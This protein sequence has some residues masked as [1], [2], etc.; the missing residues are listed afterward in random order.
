MTSRRN[1]LLKKLVG[2]AIGEDE[3]KLYQLTIERI[4]ADMCDYYQKFYHNEGPGAMVYVPD[5]EDEKKSMFYLTVNNLITAVDDLNKN[6]MEG[7]ADV[8]KQAITRAEK[9]DPDKEALFI[10]QDS[11]EMSLVHYKIDS[12]GAS[13]K[14]M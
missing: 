13:F 7:A 10:I 6:D 3:K 12:E 4:C 14:M 8:M 1:Q 11:K 9:L 5:H 2:T